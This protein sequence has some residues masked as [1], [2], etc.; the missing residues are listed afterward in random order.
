M[1]ATIST[2]PASQVVSVV[3]SVISAGSTGVQL[4]QLML[5]TNPR[6][7]IGSV[8]AFPSAATVSTYA[9]ALST[10]AVEAGVYF[11]GYSTATTLP[12]NLLIAQ[13]PTAAVGA[14]LRGGSVSG[15]SLT[16]LQAV[17]GTLSVTINGTVDTSSTIN[18]SGATSFSSAAQLINTGLGVTGAA[19]ASVTGSF[20]STFTGAASASTTLVASAVT[21]YISVGDTIAGTGVSGTVTIAS[22]V[23][24]TVGGAGTYTT[25]AI[26]SASGTITGTSNV[27]SATAVS[28]GTLAIGQLVS[29]NST[30]TGTYITA[31]GTGTGGTGTY[32][33][34]VAQNHASGAITTSVP[35]VTY[36]SISGG[37]VISSPT[38][39][40]ASTI[41]FGSGTI[42]TSLNL[43]AS[44]GAVTSQGAGAAVPGTFMT[45][46]LALNSNWATFQTLFDPD[47]GSGNAQKQL[48][49]TWAGSA[50]ANNQYMY[51]A[52]DTD[53]TPTTSTTAT[54]SLGYIL[55]QSGL[56][57][58]A[59]ISSPA[60]V[61]SHLGSF[62][63][64]YAASLN[65]NATNGRA[66]AAFKSSPSITP[67]TV[68][69]LIATNLVANGYNYYGS[70]AEA[71]ATWQ[72]FYPGQISGQFTWID[73]FLNQIWLNNQCQI[74]LM[75]LL[76]QVGRIPYNSVGYA[77]IRTVLTGGA[78][79]NAIALPPQS[80]VAAGLNNGVITQGVPLSA[81]QIIAANALAGT[82]CAT[83]L[84]T[85]GW[86]LAVQ[87]A[88][89]A[90][91]MARQSP[92]IIL[93]YMDGGSV[94]QINL[95]SV[96]VF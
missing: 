17:S 33:T 19:G 22:F 90:V 55:K 54:T 48:F 16:Q 32:V 11:Q 53:L 15:L 40:T 13:Y 52:W 79:Q 95:S 73:S 42:A 71:N 47:N 93:L 29:G 94:Q 74:A 59:P 1:S 62:L 30:N 88:T 38:T 57:G 50:S 75:N 25:S 66:T 61:S 8:V 49:A 39:G 23:S 27:L 44:L 10:E 58:T 35:T 84:S 26:T 24:G 28:S 56:S 46:I 65:F 78:T 60:G 89:A 20:G 86:Y 82:N 64:G 96:L 76:T 2:I 7:P 92:V 41:G 63:G 51:C 70:F 67:P 81:S 14:Y 4:S 83:Q 68:S 87:P 34:T 31:F 3:P 9:G 45:S 43:T 6:F 37:F 12:A 21:G 77:Q 91:R 80:P 36:D 72:F 18:L 85:Q 69:Q 5:T